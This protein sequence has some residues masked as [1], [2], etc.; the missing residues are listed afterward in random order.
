MTI[1]SNPAAETAGVQA[2]KNLRERP[3]Q[4]TPRIAFKFEHEG[5]QHTAIFD[6]FLPRTQRSK[7]AASR[8]PLYFAWGCFRDFLS[9]PCRHRRRDAMPGPGHEIVSASRLRDESIQ[10]QHIML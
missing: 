10:L 7:S 4:T 6:R 3:S 2:R 1:T 5:Q 9:R 8:G